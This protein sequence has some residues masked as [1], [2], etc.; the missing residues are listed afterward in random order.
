MRVGYVRVSKFEQEDA[1]VQQT[2]RIE[3]AGCTLIFSDIESGKSDQRKNFNKLLVMCRTGQI[4]EIV[5]TRVDR[6]ARSVVTIHRA[7]AEFQELKVKL[8][9]LDAPVDDTSSPFG[10][11]SINQMA[12]LAEFESRL[13][14]ERVK[15]GIA[16]FKEQNR[17]YQPPFG[18]TRAEGRYVPDLSVLGETGKSKWEVASA[19]V[20]YLLDHKASI[21]GTAHFINQTYGVKFSPMGLRSWLMNPVLQGHT[22]YNV[23]YNRVN[24]EKW[25]I[26]RDTHQPLISLQIYQQIESLMTENRRRWGQN[27]TGNSGVGEILLSGQIYCGCC[28]GKCYV[29]D[30]KKAMALRCKHRRVYGENGCTNKAGVPLQRVIDAVD[31]VLT[32]KAKTLAN[33][34]VTNQPNPQES[35]E[36]AELKARVEMFKKMPQDAIIT[37]AIDKTILKIQSLEQQNMQVSSIGASLRFEL[38]QTFGDGR[39][40][41]TLPSNEKRELYR[42]FVD[43][44]VVLNGDITAIFLSEVFRFQ[45]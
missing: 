44:V 4:T 5:I 11:F 41:E 12:G 1:L 16:H 8:I 10:W 15:H 45:Q 9:I 29:H 17:A 37:E 31:A 38:I 27:F 26:R 40:L 36:V 34:T 22:R 7:I 25:D 14:Q 30:K 2:A 3:K 42:K 21:R 13:L 23:K 35:P 18:Y 39:F 19:I 20:T 33:Y 28:G 24:P 32:E 6:L 43:R